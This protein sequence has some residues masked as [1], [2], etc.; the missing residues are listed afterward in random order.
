MTGSNYANMLGKL[1]RA[2]DGNVRAWSPS[3]LEDG[4]VKP[5]FPR[6]T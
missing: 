4:K 3:G 6:L 1:L 2:Y 5:L